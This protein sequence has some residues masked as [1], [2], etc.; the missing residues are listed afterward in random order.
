MRQV[1]HLLKLNRCTFQCSCLFRPSKVIIRLTFSSTY[2]ERQK[3]AL[4]KYE[5]SFYN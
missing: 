3:V 5:I 4:A 1:G 2:K